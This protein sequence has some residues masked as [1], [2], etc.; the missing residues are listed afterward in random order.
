[1]LNVVYFPETYIP[2]FGCRLV[3]PLCQAKK[4]KIEC[5]KKVMHA[6]NSQSYGL[7]YETAFQLTLKT[8][9]LCDP[10]AKHYLV[11]K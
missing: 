4:K 6:K 2:Y 10:V 7:L 9:C 5:V 8:Q 3:K 1:M 11:E